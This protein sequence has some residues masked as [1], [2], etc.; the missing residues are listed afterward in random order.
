MTIPDARTVLLTSFKRDG[1]G[2]GTPVWI[3]DLGD[4]TAGVT[5]APGSWKVKRMRRDPHVTVQASDMRGRPTPGTESV[6]VVASVHEDAATVARVERA[7]ARKYGWQYRLVGVVERVAGMV[8]R[9][10]VE[11]CVVVLA[12]ESR[13]A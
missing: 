12:P 9:H 3:V 8:R 1:G 13:G 2:V 7:L 4:G 6:D 5:T 10:E 11:R